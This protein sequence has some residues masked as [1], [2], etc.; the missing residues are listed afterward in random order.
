MIQS[1]SKKALEFGKYIVMG[2]ANGIRQFTGLATDESSNLGEMALSALSEPMDAI[3]D[4]L[5]ENVGG[6][7][8]TPVL[9]LTNVNTGINGLNSI[10]NGKAGLDLTNTMR[11]LPQSNQTNQNGILSAIRDGLSM[12]NPEVDLSGK[13]TVEVVNDKGRNCWYS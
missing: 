13:L 1:P 4:L 11:L 6:F 3:P 9:D 10:I 2:L 7:T 5:S 12:A 8:I